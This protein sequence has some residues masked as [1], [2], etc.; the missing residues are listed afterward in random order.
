VIALGFNNGGA[1]RMAAQV[2]GMR[3]S[4]S[5]ASCP[6]SRLGGRRRAL[7]R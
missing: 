1:G 4:A 6:G 3:R 2:S 7:S 5:A